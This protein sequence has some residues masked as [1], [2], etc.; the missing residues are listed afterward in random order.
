[1]QTYIITHH[2]EGSQV[3]YKN[4][5]MD[6]KI[7][8]DLFSVK[9]LSFCSQ[10]MIFSVHVFY[11]PVDFLRLGVLPFPKLVQ[12]WWSAQPTKDANK[13]P[14]ACG[15]LP[16]GSY[17]GCCLRNSQREWRDPPNKEVPTNPGDTQLVSQLVN[18]IIFLLIFSRNRSV[19]KACTEMT[20]QGNEKEVTRRGIIKNPTSSLKGKWKQGPGGGL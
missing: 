17:G 18:E 2:A 20:Q 10:I 3:S 11:Q 5:C 15:H 19:K 16:R 1:M 7:S 6:Q 13:Y 4:T 12:P 8:K 9:L 14:C